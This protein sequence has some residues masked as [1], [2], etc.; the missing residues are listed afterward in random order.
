MDWNPFNLLTGQL[1]TFS[2][3]HLA[4]PDIKMETE[5]SCQI[6]NMR[7]CEKCVRM[8]LTHVQLLVNGSHSL[9]PLDGALVQ[10][11][12]AYSLTLRGE[13]GQSKLT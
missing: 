4:P 9:N 3:F 2:D 6:I 8:C 7:V 12:E 10:V 5:L 11:R 13:E 1:I